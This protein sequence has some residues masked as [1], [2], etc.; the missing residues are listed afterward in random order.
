MRAA[1]FAPAAGAR[2]Q[3]QRPSG[4]LRKM[5]GA[6]S[7]EENSALPAA[8]APHDSDS[9]SGSTGSAASLPYAFFEKLHG[10]IQRELRALQ[11]A[12]DFFK[13][14]KGALEIWFLGRFRLFGGR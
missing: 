11:A 6:S 10:V 3:R 2:E 4:L 14:G 12:D 8:E 7:G 13:A 5:G 1:R 9:F